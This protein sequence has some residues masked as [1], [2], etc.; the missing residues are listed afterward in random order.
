MNTL[1]NPKI[2]EFIENGCGRCERYATPD[3]NV[4]RYQDII[5]ELRRIA[6][7]TGLQEEHKWSQAC[8]THNGKNI[9][10]ISAVR[11]N[12]LL[13]FFKGALLKDPE[14]ILQKPGENSNATRLFKFTSLNQALEIES[15][16][17]AYIFEAIE[18]EKAGLTIK[19]KDISEFEVPEELTHAF[20]EDPPF[21]S[22]WNNLTKGRRKSWLI[23]FNQAKQSKTKV[24]RIE[25]AKEKIFNGKGWQER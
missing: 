18:I 25:K 17:K 2:D 9:I 10:I 15:T 24:S 1:T 3:C 5:I 22:S 6:L 7:E 4:I 12:A 20:Q 8:Y 13:S 23:H 11:A 16:I 19:A 14:N 21:E